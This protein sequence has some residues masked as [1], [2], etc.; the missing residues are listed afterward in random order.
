M[1]VREEECVWPVEQA[2]RGGKAKWRKFPFCVGQNEAGHDER[3]CIFL[4][5]WF[6]HPKTLRCTHLLCPLARMAEFCE[7]RFPGSA[8]ALD[9]ISLYLSLLFCCLFLSS[10]RTLPFL[11]LFSSAFLSLS[12]PCFLS[13]RLEAVMLFAFFFL[14]FYFYSLFW[15]CQPKNQA[16]W[17]CN[18][19]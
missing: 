16:E 2:G 13:K 3:I 4:L 17:E 19:R 1:R 6:A 11:L 9:I 12:P 10:Q 18:H 15:L 14:L 8:F 7:F 5:A